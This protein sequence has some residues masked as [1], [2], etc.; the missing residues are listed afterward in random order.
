MLCIPVAV[1][2][3][4]PLQLASFRKLSSIIWGESGRE[5]TCE[6]SVRQVL[7]CVGETGSG[8]TTQLTQ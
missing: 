1:T 8:K 6:H 7:V 2:W 3:K 4:L 5:E